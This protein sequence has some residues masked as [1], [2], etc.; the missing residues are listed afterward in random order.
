[1]IPFEMSVRV[2]NSSEG[3]VVTVTL[4]SKDSSK[5]ITVS[6]KRI[7]ADLDDMSDLRQEAI[8]EYTR[9]AGEIQ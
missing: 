4:E 6:R 7:Y 3:Y 5:P 2:T 1:M 8:D 9:K